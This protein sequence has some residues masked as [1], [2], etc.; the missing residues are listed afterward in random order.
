MFRKGYAELGEYQLVEGNYWRL[1]S[2]VTINYEQRHISSAITPIHGVAN[3]A[4]AYEACQWFPKAI[5]E[6]IAASQSG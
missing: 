5:T 6:Y 4:G 3:R 1:V 2:G